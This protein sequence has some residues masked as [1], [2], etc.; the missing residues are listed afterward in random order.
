MSTKT[1]DFVPT[2]LQLPIFLFQSQLE[3]ELYLAP[4]FPVPPNTDYK[5]YHNYIDECLPPETPYL[6]G[7]HPNAEI[8]F[9]TTTSENLFRIVFEMQPR[10]SGASGAAGMSREEKVKLILRVTVL[11]IT[12]P[13]N[14]CFRGYTG[15][16]LSVHCPFVYKIY[17][18]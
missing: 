16:N 15:I 11:I 4:G 17:F 1:P 18:L 5:G 13:Q 12:P 8:E 10:D 3:G 14:E 6:Y 2:S 7:L 9:L